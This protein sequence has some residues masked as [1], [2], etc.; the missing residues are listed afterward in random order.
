MD[1]PKIPLLINR[2]RRLLGKPVHFVICLQFGLALTGNSS[3][4]V[5]IE[6]VIVVLSMNSIY[7]DTDISI[8]TQLLPQRSILHLAE[9]DSRFP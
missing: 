7:S 2:N 6:S 1:V 5:D 3:V 4:M 9:S 8:L